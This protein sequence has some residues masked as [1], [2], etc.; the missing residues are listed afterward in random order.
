MSY[1]IQVAAASGRMLEENKDSRM[2]RDA[3]GRYEY[4]LVSRDAGR[5]GYSL[6][7]RDAGR[8]YRYSLVARDAGRRYG[9]S[10]V[11]RDAGRRC[12]STASTRVGGLVVWLW[13]GSRAMKSKLY[14][15]RM[16]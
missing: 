6:V 5:Y 4:S 9:Y 1:T 12:R 13:F 2:S 10:L 15:D 11:A 3:G 16:H 14:H 8:R 7:S